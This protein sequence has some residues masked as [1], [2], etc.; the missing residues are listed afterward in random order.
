MARLTNQTYR[1]T[2]AP[3]LKKTLELRNVHEVPVIQ[4]ITINVGLG[5][6]LKDA[7]FIETVESSLTRLTG[8]K[9]VKTL[10]KKSIASFK[11]RQGMPVGMM[12]TL[13]GKRMW[14]FLDR[15]SH[16]AFA[17]VRDFRGIPLSSVDKAGNF[18]YGFRE[19]LAFPEISTEEMETV[20]GLQVNITTTAG[21]QEQG[22]ALFRALG[23]PFK[24][25]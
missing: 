23:F 4:K 15:L 10:A 6:G 9:P 3:E 11:I 20:H 7:K 5:K 8:Q 25:Q 12:V 16:V 13:R 1:A 19:H 24:K 22:L 2:V 17:R 14:D 18:S 21:N